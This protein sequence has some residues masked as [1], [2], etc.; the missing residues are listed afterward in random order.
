MTA[1]LHGYLGWQMAEWWC[2]CCCSWWEMG[3]GGSST[4][5]VSYKGRTTVDIVPIFPDQY[6]VHWVSV[7]LCSGIQFQSWG[8]LQQQLVAVL[9]GA[10]QKLWGSAVQ[11]AGLSHVY[12]GLASF[13]CIKLQGSPRV[14]LAMRCVTTSSSCSKAVMG[15]FQYWI[16]SC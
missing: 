2:C 7:L 12:W 15:V 6:W 9:M 8:Q 4:V 13:F 3:I 14:Y 1:L 10:A 16:C 5:L 11:D